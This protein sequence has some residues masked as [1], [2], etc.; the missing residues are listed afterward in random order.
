M[1]KS[2][3]W[4]KKL[5]KPTW[6]PPA[7]VFGPVWLVLYTFIAITYGFIGYQY[8][9]RGMP[10][11]LALPFLLN[12]IFNIAYSPIQ[13]RLKNLQLATVDILLVLVTLVW[14]IRAI[15]P[16]MPWVA[17][18]NLPYLVWVCYASVLQIVITMM[19]WEK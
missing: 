6:A 19:N 3:D 17:I 7:Y 16:F 11:I 13:F 15:Y 1:N 10:Y 4:Y 14:A 5:D 8:F 18:L 2:S 9:F 12:I